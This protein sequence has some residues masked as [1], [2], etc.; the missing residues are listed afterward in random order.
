MRATSIGSNWASIH[1]PARGATNLVVCPAH[2]KTLQSTLPR[3]ERRRNFPVSLVAARASIHAPARGAT[4]GTRYDC[5]CQ[6]ASIHAPARGATGVG[7]P[8]GLHV[9][10]SIH[11]PARGATRHGVLCAGN[12][13]ASI[14][15]P[16]RG[17]TGGLGPHLIALGRF[18]PRSRAGS[19]QKGLGDGGRGEGFNP[20][21]RAGSDPALLGRGDIDWELQSTLPRG[22]RHFNSPNISTSCRASIHAPARG[23][24]YQ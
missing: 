24:T 22:E 18:N 5:A 16:A 23:A 9:T 4:A 13:G 10:A 15:A 7:Q 8:L 17:A 20:R 6:D 12:D 14:H 3:G 19:D 21:S 2:L 1:A 11:A